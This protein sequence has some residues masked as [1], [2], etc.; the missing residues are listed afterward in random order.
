MDQSSDP[1]LSNDF[2]HVLLFNKAF[3]GNQKLLIALIA[4]SE[5]VTLAATAPDTAATQFL[6]PVN[7]LEG[8]V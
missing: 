8:N 6:D 4:P 7:H 3:F 2:L 5:T 1:V